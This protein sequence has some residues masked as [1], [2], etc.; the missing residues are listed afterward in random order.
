MN[1]LAIALASASVLC[2]ADAGRMAPANSSNES[3]NFLI[4][5]DFG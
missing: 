2:C 1:A 4:N 3:K 5:I